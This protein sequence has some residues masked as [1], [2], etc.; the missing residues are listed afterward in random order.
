M[1]NRVR[2]WEDWSGFWNVLEAYFWFPVEVDFFQSEKTR[3][4]V[5]A[6][7]K[8]TMPLSKTYSETN[9]TGATQPFSGQS[10]DKF[11]TNELEFVRQQLNLP[12]TSPLTTIGPLMKVMQFFCSEL[13]LWLAKKTLG[14]PGWVR[15]TIRRNFAFR[16]LKRELWQKLRRFPKTSRKRFQNDRALAWKEWIELWILW[17]NNFLLLSDRRLKSE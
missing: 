14:G 2:H 4:Q 13:V 16:A 11:R 6:A 17:R 12:L 1:E 10:Q 5:S 3:V 7:T 9:S 8:L 15:F